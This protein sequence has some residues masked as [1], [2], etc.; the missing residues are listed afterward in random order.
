MPAG[1]LVRLEFEGADGALLQVEIA[2]DRHEELSP[3]VGER[4]YLRPRRVRVFLDA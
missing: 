3:Q 2:R 1:G 4:L